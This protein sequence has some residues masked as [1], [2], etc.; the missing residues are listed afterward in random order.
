MSEPLKP[1]VSRKRAQQIEP[2][3]GHYNPF[4]GR[5]AKGSF[6]RS[7]RWKG[8]PETPGPT[9]YWH[10]RRFQEDR[11]AA[12]HGSP[13]QPKF[14]DDIKMKFSPREGPGPGEYKLPPRNLIGPSDFSK[15][16]GRRE[17]EP[18]TNRGP[19]SY[20]NSHRANMEAA[21]QPKASPRFSPQERDL[22]FKYS[23]RFHEPV[24]PKVSR[25]MGLQ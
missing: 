24:I 6:P 1:H 3:P 13:G 2:G 11:A 22:S 9:S 19:G 25:M 23:P 5:E 21:I 7:S 15:V 17:P 12:K 16:T 10:T 20:W 18:T 4:P 14:G 8:V